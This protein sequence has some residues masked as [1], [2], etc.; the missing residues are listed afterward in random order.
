VG[1]RGKD[2][3][4]TLTN[5][6]YKSIWNCHSEF[7]PVQGIYPNLK[8]NERSHHSINRNAQITKKNGF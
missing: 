2:S 3:G 1:S 4:G 7:P 5:V 6:Q 8:I